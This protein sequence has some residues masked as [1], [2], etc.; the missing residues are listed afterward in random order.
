MKWLKPFLYYLSLVVLV[1]CT[2]SFGADK[3][4]AISNFTIDSGCNVIFTTHDIART[5]IL[6]YHAGANNL[7]YYILDNDYFLGGS[8]N[9]GVTNIAI[10]D[11][12][13]YPL[14]PSGILGGTGS[15]NNGT[16]YLFA[17]SDNYYRFYTRA[18]FIKNGTSCTNINYYTENPYFPTTITSF[19]YSTTTETAR[20]KG[21]WNATSTTG[22][23]ERIEFHQFSSMLGIESFKELI[24][25]TT[26]NFDLTFD[27]KALPT[28]AGATTTTPFYADTTLFA[29]IYQYNNAYATDPFT[30][31]FDSRYKTL[32][33]STSTTIT[34]LTGISIATSTR[35]LF[36]YPEYECS[37]TSVTGCFKNALIWSF[38]PTQ[39]SIEN[40]YNFIDLIESK[41]P[42]GYF[43]VAR[44]SIQGLNKDG[45]PTANVNIPYSI[46]QY[47]FNPF[48]I[49]I[50]G[51]LWLFFLFSFYKRLKTIQI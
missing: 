17:S 49:G 41:A 1:L 23:T 5:E 22:V 39:D 36:A 18:S 44:D 11:L 7:Y 8:S 3:V 21:Y 2:Y 46:K 51:I 40:Y 14:D 26:G 25:T 48:D 12:T 38:Y 28:P 45:T 37:I 20:V 43:F 50:S 34:T 16:L 6:N 47:I 42:I 19:T 33:V 31:T 13:S 24:A 30:G 32:L 35:E 9:V 10:N 15:S 29:K 4:Q 27:Y